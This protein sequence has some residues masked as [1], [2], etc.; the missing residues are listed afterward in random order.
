[1]ER[2][3]VVLARMRAGGLHR[4]RRRRREAARRADPHP[5]VLGGGRTAQGG[6]RE[7]VRCGSCSATSSAA[8]IRPTGRCARPS[9]R[10][11]QEA[12]ERAVAERAPAARRA[13]ACRRRS[14]RSSRARATWSRWS[15]AA[16]SSRAR[17]TAPCARDGSRDR[18]SSRSS[19][20][21]RSRDGL[22]A[23]VDHRRA[24]T[25]SSH[26]RRRDGRGVE[27]RATSRRARTR[28][29][30]TLRRGA[31]R[32]QQPRGGRAAA[33]HRDAPRAA[34]WPRTLDLGDQPDVPSLALGTGLVTPLEL[35]RGLH[36][37]RRTAGGAS[38][39][40]AS[41]QV[42]DGDG[43]VV[44][45]Q[46]I[47]ARAR[48]VARGGVPGDVDAARTSSTAARASSVRS[49]GVD[50]PG[51]R[52]D[53]DDQRLQGRVVRRLLLVARGRSSGSATTAGDDGPR[54]VR[55]DAWPGPS[56]PSS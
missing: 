52:E 27:R 15:A 5:P 29:R 48:A 43:D 30:C 26:A 12:A 40:A 24:S 13:R 21:R 50:V 16:T 46:R 14:S 51:R 31:A 17:S 33:A 47:R 55:R 34:R 49:Y 45:D 41:L 56:G 42:M 1:M 32:V 53:R 22:V 44:L 18:R 37:V 9:C 23:G 3:H 8:T 54:R 35:A 6:L 25:A 10:E 39:R 20:P 38:S 19:T 7:G 2:S 36:R 11:L 28:T 4:P